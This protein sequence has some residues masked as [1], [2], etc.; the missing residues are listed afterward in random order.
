M[1]ALYYMNDELDQL[2]PLDTEKLK[3]AL[4][5]S[6]DVKGVFSE[7]ETALADNRSFLF[8]NLKKYMI[9][10]CYQKM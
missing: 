6:P 5:I 9:I 8:E 7:Y 3:F 4:F 1:L 10:K 2:S